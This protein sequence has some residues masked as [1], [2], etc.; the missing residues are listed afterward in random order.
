MPIDE[1]VAAIRAM[2]PFV[3]AKNFELSKRFYADIGFLVTPLGDDLAELRLGQHAFLLQDYFVQQWAENFVMHLMVED[4]E[5]WWAHI[6][7]LDL[8]GRYGVPRPR[9]PRMESWGLKVAYVFDPSGVL[10]H[11]AEDPVPRS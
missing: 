6:A 3:P 4:V 10:W 5:V 11:I 7:S 8:A 2:R 1:L 9:V